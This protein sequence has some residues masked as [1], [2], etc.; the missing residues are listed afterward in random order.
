MH[1]I[2]SFF[3]RTIVSVSLDVSLALDRVW[4]DGL[5][6]KL[7]SVLPDYLCQAGSDWDNKRE[8]IDASAILTLLTIIIIDWVQF[9]TKLGKFRTTF[10][11][12]QSFFYSRD[13]GCSSCIRTNYCRPFG[14][15][16][17]ARVPTT[18]L[19]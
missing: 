4:R 1:L 6:Y 18:Y 11:L 19:P 2:L 13:V 9:S 10:S 16:L 7:K 3:E 17:L 14:F 15:F 8:C 12:S 5:L